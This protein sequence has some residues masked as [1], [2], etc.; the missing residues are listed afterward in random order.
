MLPFVKYHGAGNDFV[1]IDLRHEDPLVDLAASARRICERRWGV[2]SDGLLLLLP[3]SI[4]DYRMRIFNADGSEPA[5]C[6]NGIRCLV[7][8]IFKRV[9]SAKE[10][11]IETLAGVLGCRKI[12]DEIAVN[13]GLP[14]VLQWPLEM[15]EGPAYVVNTGVPHAVLFVN[16]LNMIDVESLG[17]KIRFDL[18]FAPHGVNVNFAHVDRQGS[19]RLRT[20]E[21]GVE[22]ETLAC[23]TGAAAVAFVA[24]Q[25]LKLS[26]PIA[27]KT[28]CSFDSIQYQQQIRFLFPQNTQGAT[29]IEML[30]TAHEVF[31]GSLL[32]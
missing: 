15:S 14:T 4:A 27:T 1:L 17:R 20:Y 13:L 26:A 6:G 22:A 31:E 16:D 3:S 32:L 23:G 9:S 28:R 10:I 8:F 12:G 21:R 29:E 19:I 24:W 30:G 2:G 25:Q 18:R 5:M 11:T 7:D